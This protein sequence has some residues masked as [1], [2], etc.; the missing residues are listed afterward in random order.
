MAVRLAGEKWAGSMN[1]EVAS[2]GTGAGRTETVEEGEAGEGGALRTMPRESL[3][4]MVTAM[5]ISATA[6]S[7]HPMARPAIWALVEALP[8]EMMPKHAEARR[9]TPLA[10]NSRTDVRTM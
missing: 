6:P 3:A 5:T 8:T 4:M 10:E 2:S 7:K 9:R 1:G